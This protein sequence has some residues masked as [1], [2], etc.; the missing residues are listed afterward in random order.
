MQPNLD[1][2]LLDDFFKC[3]DVEYIIYGNFNFQHGKD[4]DV[5][6]LVHKKDFPKLKKYLEVN[7]LQYHERK[8]YSGQLFITHFSLK[9]HV[10]KDLFIGGRRVA[11]LVKLFL[12]N[13]VFQHSTPFNY[14][15]IINFDYYSIY[16]LIKKISN[17]KKSLKINEH[18]NSSNK[19]ITSILYIKAFFISVKCFLL[20]GL[21]IV[22]RF[23]NK[24]IWVRL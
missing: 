23:I 14:N 21:F 10:T 18:P 1:S 4:E 7:H 9:I 16:R 19:K 17:P 15:P 24:R 6:V 8:Y 13:K 3:V 22:P 5:D 2:K 20:N 11:Y 12:I